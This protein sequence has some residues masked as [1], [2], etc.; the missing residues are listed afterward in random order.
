M[1]KFSVITVCLNAGNDLLET[2]S[3]TLSQTYENFEIIVKDGFST[4]GSVEKLPKDDRIRL[5]QKKDSGIYDAMNQGIDAATG[6]YLVF[7]NAGDTFYAE[8]TLE[9]IA[10]QITDKDVAL[11]YGRCYNETL[12]VYSNSPLKLTPFFAY[13]SMLCHQA[14]IFRYNYMKEKMYDCGYRVCADREIL[15]DIV[16]RSHQKT[17]YI[18]TIV[19]RYKGSGFCETEENQKKIEIENRQLRE[20]FFSIRQRVK[21]QAIIYLTLPKLRK[22]IANNPKLVKSYKQAIGLIYRNKGVKDGK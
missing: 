17:Q 6:D 5:I 15:L 16:M 7:M 3:S 14:M 13:R 8:T 22:K 4:D 9:E 2:I 19:A 1:I 21:Y 11:Y 12:A 18:P 20:D 10:A